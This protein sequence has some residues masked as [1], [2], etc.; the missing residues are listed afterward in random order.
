MPRRAPDRSPTGPRRAGTSLRSAE[1]RGEEVKGEF[2]EAYLVSREAGGFWIDL[3]YA[4]QGVGIEIGY[5]WVCFSA[6]GGVGYG[7]IWRK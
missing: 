1:E 5:V 6:V 2:R 4:C 7:R 3:A